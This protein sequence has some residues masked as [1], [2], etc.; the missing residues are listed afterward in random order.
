MSYR[1]NRIKPR[2]HPFS[3]LLSFF[4]KLAKAKLR[5]ERNRLMLIIHLLE[6]LIAILLSDITFFLD[7]RAAYRKQTIFDSAHSFNTLDEHDFSITT[8]ENQ[9][10]EIVKSIKNEIIKRRKIRTYIQ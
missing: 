4:K 7:R 8:L 6:K 9:D 5:E 3:D 1:L 10:F 2:R